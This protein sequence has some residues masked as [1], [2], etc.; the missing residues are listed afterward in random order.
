MQLRSLFIVTAILEAGTGLALGLSPSAPAAALV[1]APLDTDGGLIVARI[2]G[3]ALF[4]LAVACWLARNDEQSRS[5]IGLVMAL[6]LYNMAVVGVFL[7]AGIG[8]GL[9]GTGLWP[10]AVLHTVLALWCL[11]CLRARL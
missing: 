2:A 5:A 6:L 11:V 10:A 3:A 7:Y 8:L 4:S 1:G 9:S